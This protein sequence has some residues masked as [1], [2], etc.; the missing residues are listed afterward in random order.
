[1]SSVPLI[2]SSELWNSKIQA[3]YATKVIV[4]QQ[5]GP[6]MLSSFSFLLSLE[7]SW[8]CASYTCPLASSDFLSLSTSLHSPP[9]PYGGFY[10]IILSF[11]FRVKLYSFLI[12]FVSFSM[13]LLPSSRYQCY[14]PAKVV[15]H[16]SKHKILGIYYSVTFTYIDFTNTTFYYSD[17]AN[18]VSQYLINGLYYYILSWTLCYID[19]Q[20]WVT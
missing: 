7:P 8:F 9:P 3:F 4:P 17:Q 15:K 20:Y 16:Q 6:V 12:H 11:Y 14:R 13:D 1:M 18:T 5:L 19:T 2:H 10:L